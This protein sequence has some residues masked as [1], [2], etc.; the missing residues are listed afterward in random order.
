MLGI[1]IVFAS[2]FA[3]AYLIIKKYYA[4]G[5]LLFVGLITLSV[6]TIISPDPILTGKKATNLA[7]LDIVQIVTNLLQT[8]TA[9]LGMNIM[10][11][12]GFSYYMDR[13]GAS[14]ALVRLSIKPLEMIHSPYLV[15]TAGFA[16]SMLLNVFIP[17]AAGLALLLMVSLYPVL[18]AAGVSRQSAAATILVGGCACFGPSGSNSLLA[19]DLTNMHVMDFFLNVQWRIGWFIVPFMLVAHFFVQRY[20]DKKDLASGK[21]TQADFELPNVE[22]DDKTTQS[23][24]VFY[25][26][27]PLVPVFLLFVFSPLV[28]KGI[29]MEV[30]T[31]LITSMLIAFVVDG[32]RR[33]NLKDS[34]ETLRAYPQG[35]G[36]VFTST[37]FLI[38]CAEVFAAGLTKSGGINTIIQSVSSMDAGAVAVFTVMFLIVVCSAMV[39][40]S[41][42]ASFFSFAPMIPDAAAH[43]GGNAAFMLSPLQLSSGMGRS[44]SPVAGVTIAVAGLS[45]VDPFQLIRRS[46]P[47]MIVAI[48]A[49]YVRSVMLI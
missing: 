31:A 8:R 47:V 1:L 24:P 27:F 23:V 2:V 7:A 15:M 29:R 20:F 22:Q 18:I 12:A 30:V 3:A 14:K 26:I 44:M 21:L 46:I 37:V 4:P 32:L 35:M 34:L 40:G 39:T 49:T 17:S 45:G 41:G 43:V 38:V 9:G 5:V 42:N 19:A 28:Y 11:I 25:A 48:A 36:K 33:R 13:I 6:V 10:A 16:L